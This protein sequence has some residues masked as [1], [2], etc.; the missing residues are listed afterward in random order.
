[1]QEKKLFIVL[2]TSGPNNA[3]NARSALMFSTISAAM[4]CK[5]ILFMVQEGVELMV[6]SSVEKET[7]LKPGAP[8]LK[9]RL[10]EAICAGVEFQVCSQTL[11]NKGLTEKDLIP[12]AKISGA[13][14]LVDLSLQA[15]GFLAF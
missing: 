3:A 13:A 1:M 15:S 5:T 9:Q 6:K 14:T 8:T 2:C 11:A 10:E 7:S 4:E 12:E